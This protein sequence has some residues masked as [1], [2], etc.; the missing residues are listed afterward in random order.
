MTPQS[1]DPI[2][3]TD[4]ARLVGISPGTARLWESQGLV[5]PARDARGNRL[6][7]PEDVDRLRRIKWLRR[8]RGL[9][10]PAIRRMLA[11]EAAAAPP[12]QAKG[13]IEEQRRRKGAALRQLRAQTGLTVRQAADL[14]GLSISFL[15][16]VERGVSG[17]SPSA[18]GRLLEALEGRG[19]RVPDV[20]SRVHTLGTEKPLEVASGITYEILSQRSGLMDPQFCVLAPGAQS[21]EE[22][23]HE[24][25]EFIL[26]LAGE[27]TIWLNGEPSVLRRRDSLHFSSQEPHRWGNTGDGTAEILWVTTERG[28]WDGRHP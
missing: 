5:N 7:R 25:E 21:H 28:L 2:S 15:S 20:V 17:I 6:Y 10:A 22:Y 24:G 3:V 9:N 23:E 12:P 18:E 8:V 19:P 11:E 14:A 27:F 16:S 1:D 13:S 26:V 4:A